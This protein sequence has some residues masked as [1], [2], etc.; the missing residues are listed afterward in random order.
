MEWVGPSSDAHLYG[1]YDQDYLKT[2]VYSTNH[3]FLHSLSIGYRADTWRG[4]FAVR[5]VTNALA[6]RISTDTKSK[7]GD[8]LYYSGYDF[9]GRAYTLS[10][11][12]KF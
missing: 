2:I 11:N 4:T 9:F 8:M 10:I 3:Y 12:K 7:L 5:N 6:P 1:K